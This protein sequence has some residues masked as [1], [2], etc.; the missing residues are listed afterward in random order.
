MSRD[1]VDCRDA[2]LRHE[3]EVE[4]WSERTRILS[5]R[6]HMVG[7]HSMYHSFLVTGFTFV[8]FHISQLEG[9][10]LRYCVGPNRSYG[11]TLGYSTRV[12]S[13]A[14]G[15][16]GSSVDGGIQAS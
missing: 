3:E 13:S 4:A 6:D 14:E 15:V 5:M 10:I 9:L 12:D 1:C 7:T 2:H 11:H 8:G 16:F